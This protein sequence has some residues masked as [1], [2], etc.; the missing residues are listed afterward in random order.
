[1]PAEVDSVS[2]EGG[3]KWNL[4]W[5]GGPTGGQMVLTLLAEVVTFYVGP[6][7]VEVRGLDLE[8]VSRSTL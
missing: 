1:M 8:F 2:E 6:T 3:R 5:P 4:V 7:A